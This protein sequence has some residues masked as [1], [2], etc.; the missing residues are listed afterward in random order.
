VIPGLC[1]TGACVCAVLAAIAQGRGQSLKVC[2]YLVV[3][4]AAACAAIYT[5]PTAFGS[6]TP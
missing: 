4:V 1:F 6:I 5:L 2:L 3:G